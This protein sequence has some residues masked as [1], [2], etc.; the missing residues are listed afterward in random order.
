[1]TSPLASLCVSDV[2]RKCDGKTGL[3]KTICKDLWSI[4]AAHCLDTTRFFHEECKS[5]VQ[6]LEQK[7]D[8]CKWGEVALTPLVE[9]VASYV[10]D[11]ALFAE[12]AQEWP[13][14]CH[15]LQ[16][17]LAKKAGDGEKFCTGIEKDIVKLVSRRA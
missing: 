8:V 9:A 15:D 14:M 4:E 13:T 10:K 11:P 1:M 16:S 7:D 5:S 12:F 3:R 2:S 17:V 6:S